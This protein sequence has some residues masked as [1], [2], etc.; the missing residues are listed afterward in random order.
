MN[1]KMK[2]ALAAFE[3]HLNNISKEE[4]AENCA[5]AKAISSENGVKI[6]EFLT[7]GRIFDYNLTAKVCF[8]NDVELDLRML[9]F[10][11]GKRLLVDGQ[12]LQVETTH[13]NINQTNQSKETFRCKESGKMKS[14]AE[15]A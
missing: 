6:K 8:L 3:A 2:N 5:K 11:N 12:G 14:L 4:F 10:Q 9:N 13:I 1:D 15:A 7:H